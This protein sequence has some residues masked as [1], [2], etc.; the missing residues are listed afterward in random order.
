MFF[1]C[2]SGYHVHSS[3][4]CLPEE[5]CYICVAGVTMFNQV[6]YVHQKKCVVYVLWGVTI[7]N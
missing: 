4:I 2:G 6:L 1:V 5:V 7:F 3:V